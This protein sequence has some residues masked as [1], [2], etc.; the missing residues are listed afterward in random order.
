MKDLGVA[1]QIFG[2]EIHRDRIKGK[3]NVSHEKYVEKIIVRFRMNK[4]NPVNVPLA[5]PFNISSGLCPSSVE[6]KDYM[7][8]VRYAN[9]IGC[10]IYA[11]VCTRPDISHAV[12]V[13][14]KYM[15]NIGKE[16]WNAVKWVFWYIRAKSD[17]CITFNN[18]NDFVFGFVD[19]DFVGD[20]DM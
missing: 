4:E 12:G 6:E 10:L 7:S 18:N 16:H 13:I 17:H 19:L 2:I 15:E 1:K 20:L 9:T 11:M 14:S 5:S 3:H 8:H